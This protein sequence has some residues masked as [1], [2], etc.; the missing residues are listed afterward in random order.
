MIAYARGPLLQ[1]ASVIVVIEIVGLGDITAVQNVPD[2]FVEHHVLG[3]VA[4]TDK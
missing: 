1:V 3:I 4:G 2:F